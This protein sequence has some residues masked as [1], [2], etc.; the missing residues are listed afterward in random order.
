M[1]AFFASHRSRQLAIATVPLVLLGFSYRSQAESDRAQYLPIG[2]KVQIGEHQ[3]KLE[4]A[5]TPEQQARGL[6]FRPRLAD[7]RGMLFP[8]PQAR[9]VSF[10]MFN[11]PEPLDMIFLYQGEIRAI[12]AEAPPCLNLPCPSYGPALVPIDAVLELRAGR[13]QELGLKRG[14]RLEVRYL[15][16]LNQPVSPPGEY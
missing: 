13:S 9:P 14:D 10:W 6:M 12:I 11:T 15:Q 2:A 7:N 16:P 8:F 1:R 3:L 5:A 4:V